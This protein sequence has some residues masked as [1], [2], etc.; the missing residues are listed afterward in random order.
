V[1]DSSI[2]QPG[3]HLLY[4]PKG[5]SGWIITLKTWH[6]IAHCE[7][8]I[9]NNYSVAS[10]NGRGVNTYITNTKNIAAVL[11]FKPEFN[12][13]LNSAL[14]WFLQSCRGQRYDWLGLLRFTWG[15]DYVRGGKNNRQFCSE[16]LTRFDRA[17]GVDPFNGEDADAVPPFMFECSPVF[18]IIWRDGK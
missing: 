8:Y 1:F 10:R 15:R 11:R 13:K 5:I 9:G 14:T 18:D 2:L 17:G 4:R 12:F 3:D 7:C 6:K 16:F